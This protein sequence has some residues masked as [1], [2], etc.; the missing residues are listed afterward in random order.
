MNPRLRRLISATAGQLP[1][2]IRSGIA[3]G[4]RWTLFPWTS[5]WR[6]THEPAIQQALGQVGGGNIRGWSCWDL[7]AHFGLYSVAL[8]IRVG[9]RGEVAA[10]EPNPESFAR[11]TRHKAMN[12]LPWLKIYEMAAS[13]KT[14]SSELLTYGELDSTS[15]HLRYEDEAASVDSKPIGIRTLRLDDEVEAGR[16][17]APQF[18][19]I[20]VEGHGHKAVEGMRGTLAKSKP[21]MIIAFHSSEEVAGVTA[22][23]KPLGYARSAIVTPPSDPD[24]LIGGDY[25]FTASGTG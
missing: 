24:S 21:T 15:T 18:V 14:G 11:L 22:I 6:G 23:L 1:V 2:T 19:K 12:R 5:Y 25:L 7:G 13:D 3:K 10:F 16:L 4:A 20:D 8:A 17:R 9:D